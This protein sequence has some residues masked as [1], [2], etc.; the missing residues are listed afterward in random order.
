MD[1]PVSSPFIFADS[2]RRRFGGT[3]DGFLCIMEIIILTTVH[4]V[5]TFHSIWSMFFYEYLIALSSTN[6][7]AITSDNVVTNNYAVML[8]RQ[9]LEISEEIIGTCKYLLCTSPITNG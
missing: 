4:N 3:C 6:S 9:L 1:L 8:I 5:F 7:L 2:E